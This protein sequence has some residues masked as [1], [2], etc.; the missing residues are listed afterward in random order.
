MPTVSHYPGTTA[1]PIRVPFG[2]GRGELIDL[3]GLSRG[4]LEDHVVAKHRPDLVMRQRVK[5]VQLVIKPGQS[6]LISG[7]V[8]ITPHN[9]RCDILGVPLCASGITCDFNGQSNRNEYSDA[10]LRGSDNRKARV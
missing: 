4:S 6:L 2:N 1:S 9:T 3:P 8:R 7:L 10:A 5:P